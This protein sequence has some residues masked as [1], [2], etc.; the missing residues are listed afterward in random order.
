[1]E[2]TDKNKKEISILEKILNS[3][4]FEG[5]EIYKELLK[6]LV[7]KY[8][9]GETP[10][11]ITIAIDVLKQD[12]DFNPSENPI[13][14]VHMHKL[15]KM[16]EQYYQNEGKNDEVKLKIPKGHYQVQFIS[17]E[18]SGKTTKKPVDKLWLIL[19]IAILTIYSGIISYMFFN[20][21][22]V[23]FPGIVQSDPIWD[24]F[25][26]NGYPT[27]VVIGDFLVFHEWD[28]EL[29]KTRR[30]QDYDINT[31][32]EF[33]SYMEAH[34]ERQ[35]EKWVLG[36]IP[37]NS[38]YNI[39]DLHRLFLSYKE[40][41]HIAFSSEI[42]IHFIKNRN[43]IY[44]GEFKNL[45]ALS[46]LLS[47]IPLEIKTLPWWHGEISYTKDDT[48]VTLKTFHDWSISRYVVD[49]GMVAKLPGE[50]N[51]NYFLFAGFGYNSQ[52]K[53]TELFTQS[54]SLKSIEKQIIELNKKIPEHFIL[55]LEVKGFDRASTHAEI[56]YF[57]PLDKTSVF[58]IPK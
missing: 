33:N 48:S 50:N 36:E 12:T 10:K 11:E 3:K 31:V 56:K 5:K 24:H 42:D 23:N 55:L 45:R 32:E 28:R 37:H 9:Q 30:I 2:Y 40:K 15:R 19:P 8:F 4:P 26:A 25:F 43:T 14:R 16:L 22:Y 54:K 52:I 17:G 51:E 46:N 34:K 18:T 44:I 20:R 27:S 35:P 57:K 38:L 49:I 41:L 58:T 7:D 13:V 53:M 21:S 39:L 29:N 1:M 6:Y 47:G